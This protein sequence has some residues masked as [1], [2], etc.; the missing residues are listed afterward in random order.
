[1]GSKEWSTSAYWQG[2]FEQEDTPWQ[3]DAVSTVLIEAL[4]ELVS[5]GYILRGKRVLSAGCGRGLDALELARH[6]AHVLAVDWSE[7][8]VRDLRTQ[9]ESLRGG[10]DGTLEVVA[11][12]FFALKPEPLDLVL[13]HTFFCAVDPSL[14]SQYV[15]RMAEWVKPCGYIVGNFFVLSEEEVVALSNRSLSSHGDGPPFASTETEL[16][17]LFE[18]SFSCNVLRPAR[19][20]APDR[21]PGME[22]VGL[23]QRK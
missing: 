17:G 23:F 22:W 13:E 4:N 11:G 5:L 14:R 6:G 3:L 19:S 7:R 8:A 21:R 12:D 9:W 20:S 18:N 15:L 10:V 16:R 1:M 2:R